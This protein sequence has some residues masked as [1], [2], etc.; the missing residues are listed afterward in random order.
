MRPY[1]PVP[2]RSPRRGLLAFA[3]PAVVIGLLGLPAPRGEAETTPELQKQINAA[4]EKGVN[5]LENQR[6]FDGSFDPVVIDNQLSHQIGTTSLCALALLAAGKSRHDAGMQK[7]LEWVRAQDK[8][9][10]AGKTRATY[11][12]GVMLMF[13][14]E[15]FRPDA[16]PDKDK[17]RYAKPKEKDPCGLPADVRQWLEEVAVWFGEVQLDDGWWR[18]PAAPPGDL[19]NTQYALLGLRAAHDC[20]VKISPQIFQKACEATLE[21]QEKDGPKVNRIIPSGGKPGEREYAY[22]RGDRARG[23][24]YQKE[25]TRIM[26]SMTTAALAVLSI[27]NDALIKPERFGGYTPELE[28]KVVRSVQDGFAWLDKNYAVDKNP[29][30]GAPAW[31]YYYLY[32][33]ERACAFGGVDRDL[34]GKHEWYVDGAKLLVAQQQAADGRWST[35]ALGQAE[36]KIG[37]SDLCDTAW[38]LLFLKKA[39]KPTIPIRPPVV[40]GG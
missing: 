35:G 7:S 26:G 28:K 40:T 31:H 3:V 11:D 25:G 10:S 6:H 16:K 39:T 24:G 30:P 21:A 36:A 37:G 4:I 38:A 14:V 32:G 1:R 12:A 29:P 19:S 8:I 5:W 9:V 13:A 18:Y 22:D 15:M 27:C 23:W 2:A 33:L 17:G 20:G 34:I